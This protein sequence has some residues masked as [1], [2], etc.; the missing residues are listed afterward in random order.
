MK[1]ILLV[2]VVVFQAQLSFASASGGPKQVDS[3]SDYY[4]TEQSVPCLEGYACPQAQPAKSSV[5][6]SNGA[7]SSGRPLSCTD[8]YDTTVISYNKYQYC[9]ELSKGWSAEANPI[10]CSQS[11]GCRS[12][13]KVEFNRFVSQCGRSLQSN[14]NYDL[15]FAAIRKACGTR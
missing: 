3:V 8:G 4:G 15:L 10:V 7:D 11:L 1:N 14:S 9:N 12:Q 13:I 6:I 5:A 2:L